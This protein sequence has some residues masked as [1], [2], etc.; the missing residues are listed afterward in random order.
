MVY[1][2]K[3]R[4]LLEPRNYSASHA[5]NFMLQCV[6][7]DRKYIINDCNSLEDMLRKLSTYTS[8]EG[9]YLLK[10]VHQIKS[11]SK[12]QTYHEDKR[13]LEFFDKALA[14]IT[15]LNSAFILD[16]LTAQVM[17]NKLSSDS[18]RRKYM[19]KLKDLMIDTNDAHKVNNYLVTMQQIIVKAKV[20]IDM[21]VDVN[22]GDLSE[23]AR[24]AAVYS[25]QVYGRGN[26]FRGRY[27]NHRGN[28]GNYY[29]KR[30]GHQSNKEHGDPINLDEK[31][32]FLWDSEGNPLDASIDDEAFALNSS[33]LEI[34]KEKVA[35]RGGRGSGQGRGSSRGLNRESYQGSDR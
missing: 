2:E 30:G 3:W 25:T 20:E 23:N 28:R 16:Y 13:L 35:P 1:I 29:N 26:D 22:Q 15:K 4:R 18:M 24:Q 17:I 33:S 14:N 19:G 9:T 11:R 31:G 6:P 12:S 21:I 34:E 7:H 8:D 27:N 32:N 5:V 10:I